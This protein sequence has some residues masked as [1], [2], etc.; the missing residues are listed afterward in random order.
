MWDGSDSGLI[1]RDISRP[2]ET[3]RFVTGA[4]RDAAFVEADRVADALISDNDPEGIESGLLI[5]PS[6]K[7][8]SILAEVHITHTYVSDLQVELIAPGG[9]TAVLHSRTGGGQNNLNMS[10]DLGNT[11]ALQAFVGTDIKG[12]WRLRLRDMARF[13]EGRL[14]GWSLQLKYTS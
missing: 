14:E 5:G 6:G 9:E 10:Y 4:P 8:T 7:L 11:P 13:D 2:G 3:M 1:I 12:V